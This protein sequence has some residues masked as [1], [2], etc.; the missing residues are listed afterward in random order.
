MP[1]SRN[2]GTLTSW[3]PLGPSGFV[4]GLIY[5]YFLSTTK[6][7]FYL[8]K[9]DSKNWMRIRR[10]KWSLPRRIRNYLPGG[11]K[12]EESELQALVSSVMNTIIF[13]S[14]K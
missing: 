14:N 9:R 1:L 5:L 11:S 8:L 12:E 10:V 6:V 2:L 13:L 3:N 4:T 7:K